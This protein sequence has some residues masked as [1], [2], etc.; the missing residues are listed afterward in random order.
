MS[1]DTEPY[2][3]FDGKELCEFCGD[4]YTDKKFCSEGCATAFFND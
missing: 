2:Q 4:V 3:E 1:W